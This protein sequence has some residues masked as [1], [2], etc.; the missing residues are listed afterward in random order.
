ML[1]FLNI[2]RDAYLTS[3]QEHC[4]S[5]RRIHLCLSVHILG[6]EKELGYINT[7]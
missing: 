6:H 3:A 4:Y 1:A 7:P 2:Q 5:L